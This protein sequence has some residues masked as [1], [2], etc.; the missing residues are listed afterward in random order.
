MDHD[1]LETETGREKKN[2]GFFYPWKKEENRKRK[3]GKKK[4]ED[5]M[6]KS[7]WTHFVT[8]GRKK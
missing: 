8:G 6:K 4:E 5:R 3:N 1:A 2:A 7:T